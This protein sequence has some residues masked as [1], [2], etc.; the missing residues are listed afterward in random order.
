ME[1]WVLTMNIITIATSVATLIALGFTIYQAR[2]TRETLI[3]TRK[4]IDQEKVNRQISLLP[5]FDWIIQVEVELKQWQE[6]L[7][8]RSQKLKDAF[9]NKDSSILEELSKTKTRSPSDLRLSRYQYE[10]MPDW[11]SQLWLSGAQYYFDAM[12]SMQ[13]LYKDN[14][15]EFSLAE[16][17]SQRCDRSGY[18]IA[19]LRGYIAGMVPDVILETPASTRNSEFFR[20]N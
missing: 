15:G 19:E 3:E 5:K 12:A 6:D 11:L 13:F 4:S 10:N 8:T 16:M 14:K 1:T 2:L 18:S 7:E 20:D 9:E 17:L